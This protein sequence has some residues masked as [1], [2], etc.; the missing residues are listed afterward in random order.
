MVNIVIPLAGSSSFFKEN[1]IIFPKPFA[2]IC[3]KTMIE[4]LIENYDCIKDKQ[5]IFIL[6]ESDVRGFHLDEAIKVLAPE[7][8]IITLKKETQGMACSALL[9]VEFIDNETPLIIAN[10]DQIFE[11]DLTKALEFFKI[12]SAG[13]ITFSSIHPRWA[14]VR[15]DENGEIVE[16]LEKNPVSKSAIAGF[17]YFSSGGDFVK[18]AQKMIEKDASLEGKFFIAPALN[19]LILDGKSI[20]NFKVEKDSYHTFYSIDKIKEYERIKN[21]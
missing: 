10:A 20:G 21:G 17:Y 4:L 12:Y 3:G 13:V 19:E 8:K 7:S 1:E 5:F 11:I 15:L 18:A 6:K 16:V 2:E 9:A 14:Y